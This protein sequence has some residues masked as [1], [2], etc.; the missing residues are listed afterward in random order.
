MR[1]E[2]QLESLAAIQHEIW[3]HWMRYLFASSHEN[4]DGSYTIPVDKAR[5]WQRQMYVKYE[6]LTDDEK[7]SDRDQARKIIRITQVA[8]YE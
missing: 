1:N 6:D 8:T 7:E 2:L 4:A 5:R 3:S